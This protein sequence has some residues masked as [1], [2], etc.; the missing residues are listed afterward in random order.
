MANFTNNTTQLQ[1]LLAKVNALPE[2]GSGG[3]ASGG[4]VDTCTVTIITE[5]KA[6]SGVIPNG[7]IPIIDDAGE[8]NYI[9]IDDVDSSTDRI[10]AANSVT[11]YTIENVSNPSF[12][13]L[14]DSQWCDGTTELSGAVQLVLFDDYT[15]TYHF[16]ISGDCTIRFK[17]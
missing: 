7:I 6:M 8:L 4:S 11:T 3:G 14:N 1:N 2:A 9:N 17:V 12:L 10:D 15:Y 16:K 13:S 5:L